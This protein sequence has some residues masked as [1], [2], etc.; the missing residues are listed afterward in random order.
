MSAGYEVLDA[1]LSRSGIEN[2]A[3]IRN[4]F[5]QTILHQSIVR[6]VCDPPSVV[7]ILKAFPDLVRFRDENGALPIEVACMRGLDLG[8]IFAI[9]LLDLPIDPDKETVEIRDGFGG[10]WSY[11]NCD[12]DDNYVGI[13]IELLELCDDY[14]QK[15]TLC[16]MKN[17]QGKSLMS[18]ATPKCKHELRK[19]LRFD[20]RYEFIGGAKTERILGE[21]VKVFDALDFGTDEDL[22]KEGRRVSIRYYGSKDAFTRA[23]SSICLSA[24]NRSFAFLTF[25]LNIS[26]PR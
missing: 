14:H 26:R 2:I 7:S 1:L 21:D 3:F 15:R 11:L 25:T 17:K 19:S 5:G 23:V 18:R 6:E 4:E 12:C 20:A 22:R 10:S 13:V 24:F 16:F 8:V 9:A